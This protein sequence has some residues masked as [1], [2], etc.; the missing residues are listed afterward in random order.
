MVCSREGDH[1]FAVVDP[2]FGRRGIRVLGGP[3]RRLIY[4]LTVTWEGSGPG[5]IGAG[6][7]AGVKGKYV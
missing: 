4:V 5:G 3:S 7:Q 1:R 2:P 6:C